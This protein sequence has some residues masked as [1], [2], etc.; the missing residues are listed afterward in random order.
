M[1]LYDDR[2]NLIPLLRALPHVKRVTLG[3]PN[4]TA[5]LP[6]V[7]ITEEANTPDLYADD[8]A[9]AVEIV[10]DLKVFAQK[11]EQMHEIASAADDLMTERGYRRI[12]SHEAVLDTMR[13]KVLRY[14]KMF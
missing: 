8:K 11:A 7:A 2:P 13:Y 12:L 10:Y 4:S 5:V 6:C 3:W 9:Y 14:T 1:A